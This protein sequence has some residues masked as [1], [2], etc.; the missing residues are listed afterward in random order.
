MAVRTQNLSDGRLPLWRHGRAW[1]AGLAIEWTLPGRRLGF[2]VG[3]SG[4]SLQLPLV[5]EVFVTLRRYYDSDRRELSIYWLDGCLWISHPF[6]RDGGMEW[7]R[8][9]PWW[10]G[11]IC[12]HVVDWILGR[13]RYESTKGERFQVAV[14]MPE[15]CYL[16]LATPERGVWRR[17]WYVPARVRESVWL[18]IPGGI[19]HSGKGENSW[20]CGDDGLCGIGGENVE[21]AIANAVRSS[22]KSR[23]RYGLA[24]NGAGRSPA[25]VLNG[26]RFAQERV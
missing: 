17:R 6:E 25:I 15:G 21:D 11:V 12:L 20:D 26:E 9:D 1:L 24:S 18:E 8:S 16:A 4:F 19:P 10:R 3:L 23:R 2:S 22:L 5:A 13:T 14:P 7:R